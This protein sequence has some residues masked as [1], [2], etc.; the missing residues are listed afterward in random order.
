M[1]VIETIKEDFSKMS[2]SVQI[3]MAVIG[4]AAGYLLKQKFPES[5]V[6]YMSEG[7]G[8]LAGVAYDY[9]AFKIRSWFKARKAVKAP[10][11]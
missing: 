11:P 9:L 6:P 7:I 4:L 10:V 1:A 5:A 8:M 2:T 3:R